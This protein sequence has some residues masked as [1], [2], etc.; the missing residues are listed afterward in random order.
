[1]PN[2][3]KVT[4]IDNNEASHLQS[5]ILALQSQLAQTEKALTNK[6]KQFDNLVSVYNLLIDKIL[7]TGIER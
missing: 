6:T 7:N 5:Q 1:M 3:E 4:G 2:T